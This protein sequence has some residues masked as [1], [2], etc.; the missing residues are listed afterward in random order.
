VR[1]AARNCRASNESTSIEWPR[2]GHG[3]L[4]AAPTPRPV[5]RGGVRPLGRPSWQRSGSGDL[6]AEGEELTGALGR[7]GRQDALDEVAL[8]VVDRRQVRDCCFELSTGDASHDVVVRAVSY[9]RGLL[10]VLTSMPWRIDS[11]VV[12][13]FRAVEKPAGRAGL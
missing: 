2:G 11:S 9:L 1:L 6:A 13:G 5:R 4:Q 3:P 10:A 12:P 7:Q 8:L